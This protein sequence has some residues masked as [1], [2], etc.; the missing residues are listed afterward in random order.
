MSLCHG[1]AGSADVLLNE[2]KASPEAVAL[3]RHALERYGAGREPWPCGVPG[4]I[5]P[6]LFLGLSGVGWWFLRLHDARTP[7]PLETWG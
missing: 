2:G 5:T 6:G 3:G 7:S 4:G 1:A